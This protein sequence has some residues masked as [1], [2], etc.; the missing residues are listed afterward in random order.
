LL[1]EKLFAE[2]PDPGECPVCLLR[3]PIN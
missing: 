2:P 1:E 3:L